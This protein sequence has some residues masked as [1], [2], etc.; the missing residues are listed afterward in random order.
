[1]SKVDLSNKNVYDYVNMGEVPNDNSILQH[2]FEDNIQR[3]K[4]MYDAYYEQIKQL[5][6]SPSSTPM[7][8][9]TPTPTPTLSPP[10]MART[11]PVSNIDAQ[12]NPNAYPILN[13]ISSPGPSPSP[14]PMSPPPLNQHPVYNRV[15]KITKKH[16][17]KRSLK[18]FL[19]FILIILLF[20][21]IIYFTIFRLGWG[22]KQ[23]MNKSYHDCAALLTPELAPL[24]A[25][26]LLAFL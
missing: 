5:S 9:A 8:I 7:A 4:M 20:I 25:T 19:V 2:E 17:P 15:N 13:N 12:F 26:G 16:K 22:I 21:W 10:P 6:E 1:M 11:I 23:C 14:S 24:A 18:G 3:E